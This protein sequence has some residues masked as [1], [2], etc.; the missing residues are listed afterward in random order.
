MGGVN[1]KVPFISSIHDNG[2][3]SCGESGVEDGVRAD[4]DKEKYNESN[5][6]H[7]EFEVTTGHS[8]KYW[9]NESGAQERLELGRRA[10]EPSRGI[11]GYGNEPIFTSQS[12]V[13]L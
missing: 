7:I 10:F 9:L 4:K 13:T 2:V 3:P 1:N 12:K 8:D 5:L 11:R 6:E